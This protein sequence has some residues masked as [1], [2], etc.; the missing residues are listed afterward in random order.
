[1]QLDLPLVELAW[2]ISH[3]RWAQRGLRPI[4]AACSSPAAPHGATSRRTLASTKAADPWRARQLAARRLA[5]DLPLTGQ[6]L[7]AH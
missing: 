6:R 7:P 4:L 5:R 3:R 2:Q 1:V